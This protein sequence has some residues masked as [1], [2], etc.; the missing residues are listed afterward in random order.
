MVRFTV[1]GP[2][3]AWRDGVELAAGPPQQ[4]AMLALL[5]AQAGRPVSLS[6]IVHVLW[7]KNPPVSAVNVVHRYVGMVRRLLEPALAVREEGRWLVR[8][9]G[10]YRLDVGPGEVDLLSFRRLAEDARRRRANGAAHAA[11]KL[12]TEALALWHGPAAAGI[13]ADVRSHPTFTALDREQLAAVQEAADLALELGAADQVLAQLWETAARHPL[14]EPVQ[15]RLILALGA[16]G[17]QAEALETWHAVRARLARELGAG[18]GPELRAAQRRIL[19][20]QAAPPAQRRI[21][22]GQAAPAP[23][24]MRLP[25]D[26]ATFAGRRAGLAKA[27][28]LLLAEDGRSPAVGVIS[29]MGGIG[30]STFAIHLAHQVAHRFPDG[31]LY[32]DL[33]GH[34]PNGSALAPGEALRGLLEALGVTPHRIPDGLDARA[35]LYRSLLSGRR[36]LIVLDDARDAEQVRPLLPGSSGCL[37]LTTSRTGLFGLI[38]EGAHPLAIDP[39]PADEAR[40]LLARRLGADLA[41]SSPE[42]V[43]RIV[44]RCAGLPLA[45]AVVAARAADRPLTAVAAELRVADGSLG[46]FSG[47]AAD[48]D[49]RAVFSWS[50][51]VL[52]PAA[53]RLFRLLAAHPGPDLGV[54]AAASVAGMPVG[55]ARGL[56]TELTSACL[57]TE[58][59]PGRYTCHELLRAYAT[60]LTHAHDTEAE[61]RAAAHRVFD[62]Y[63][64]T[65]HAAGRLY[66]PYWRTTTLPAAR[67]GVAAETFE[68]DREALAWFNREH[69]V[70]T[71][72]IDQA[73]RE[74]FDTHAWQL[75]WA[76]ERFFDRQGHW[77]DFLAAQRAGLAA[78][79]RVGHRGARAHLH[80][81][82]ARAA[83]RLGRFDDA[84][85][86]VQR[87]LSLFDE[88]DDLPG[89][90][91][92]HR[93]HGWILDQQ[94]R[95]EAA[96]DAA[97]HALDLYQAIGDRVA[98]GSALHA[99]GWTHALL[100]DLRRATAYFEQALATT[101]E[102]R[103]RYGAGG[104]L[105]SLGY[106][107]HHLGDHSQAIACY[108][109]ALRL[110]RDVGDRYQEAGTL[111]RLGETYLAAGDRGTTRAVWRQAAAILDA[112]DPPAA[113]EVRAELRRIDHAAGR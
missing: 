40:E 96:L 29:G 77:H 97:K 27:L 54:A 100:G 102:S 88:L 78:A 14:D 68:D 50:Y 28:A 113:E 83:A 11:L 59:S 85:T 61:R 104:T 63:L 23:G 52:S 22:H 86:H 66:S 73:V 17:R 33:R 81:G 111:R 25:P 98:G 60:E 2:V 106:A 65:A 110:Y 20:G 42:A 69:L 43:D 16:G 18:P 34:A 36:A 105:D 1:L 91:H 6:E 92:A 35:A 99:L 62:H 79:V 4:R 26:L 82:L 76:L 95:H 31:R 58:H 84:N 39:L 103:D 64:R 5:L 3:R 12:M 13:P 53:A 56:L 94:G 24:P 46:A 72:M 80:R 19:H 45:L 101:D 48:G 74:G 87:A 71:S 109:R 90:A 8:D 10:G 49:V 41:A 9:R 7:G 21:L 107:H 57:L 30:K 51:R 108:E 38:A 15:A 89:L 32:V 93:C 44:A 112:A 55:H 70:L 47:P 67:P 75:A 37:V